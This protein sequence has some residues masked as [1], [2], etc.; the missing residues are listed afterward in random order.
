MRLFSFWL[1]KKI[2]ERA[3]QKAKAHRRERTVMGKLM[4]CLNAQIA[5]V[6][7][8]RRY[9]VS[10]ET[11]ILDYVWRSGH[12]KISHGW[13]SNELPQYTKV[14]VQLAH[15]KVCFMFLK[16]KA[17]LK[18]YAR[19]RFAEE[20]IF[21]WLMSSRSVA[22]EQSPTND[23]MQLGAR[24]PG[25]RPPLNTYYLCTSSFGGKTPPLLV[26]L[27]SMNPTLGISQ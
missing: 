25:S 7:D 23:R 20:I 14:R 2:G 10:C 26:F 27:A 16:P 18:V 11:V 5:G 9:L 15:L 21:V 4:G 22:N 13:N 19:N 1:T 17:K 3:E 12:K 24:I 6:E 8:C